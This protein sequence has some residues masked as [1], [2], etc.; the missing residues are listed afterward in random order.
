MKKLL[1]FIS[2]VF[3]S[4]SISSCYNKLILTDSENN[5]KVIKVS[6]NY[7]VLRDKETGQELIQFNTYKGGIHVIKLEK[8]DYNYSFKNK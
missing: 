6:Q 2:I 5:T 8:T 7:R 1:V 3:F 4:L